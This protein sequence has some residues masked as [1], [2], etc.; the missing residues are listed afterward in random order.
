MQIGFSCTRYKCEFICEEHRDKEKEKELWL[1]IDS[2][3]DI[4]LGREN[5]PITLAFPPSSSYNNNESKVVRWIGTDIG[6]KSYVSVNLDCEDIVTN[7]R[8]VHELVDY[9]NCEV[10]FKELAY[11]ILYI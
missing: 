2:A 4:S 8:S 11:Y 9:C 5:V 1:D 10:L 7:N 6:L 3:L